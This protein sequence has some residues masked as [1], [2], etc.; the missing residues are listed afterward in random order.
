MK[1]ARINAFLVMTILILSVSSFASSYWL[2][3]EILDSSIK[4]GLNQKVSHILSDYQEGLKRLKE[5]DPENEEAYKLKFYEVQNA[6]FVYNKPEQMAQ[7]I[8][9]S[10]LSYFLIVFVSI[11]LLSLLVSFFVSKKISKAYKLLLQQDIKKSERIHQLEYF[12]QWQQMAANLA[13]EIKNPLTP[14]EMM[15]T[16]LA[17][18]QQNMGTEQFKENIQLTRRVVLEEVDRLKS[19]VS[20]FSQFSRLPEPQLTSQCFIPLIQ[21]LIKMLLSTWKG[22]IV[23]FNP[24]EHLSDLKVRVD[25]NLFKQCIINLVKNAYEANPSTEKMKL[26]FDVSLSPDKNVRF[27]FSNE[28]VSLSENRLKEIFL[29][30]TSTHAGKNNQ[31]LGLSIVRKIMLDHHGNIECIPDEQGVSFN[32]TLPVIK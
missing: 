9:R 5:L 32:L 19:M 14:I 17:D 25:Q 29:V 30:G 20:H 2:L 24:A 1:T 10:Y 4:L 27:I 18:S 7:V 13:H 22:L 6:M 23:E 11:L 26:K 21:S 15:V 12:D 28:G 16:N 3:D 8:K 31:G